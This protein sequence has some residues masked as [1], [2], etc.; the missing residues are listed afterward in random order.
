M[1]WQCFL[2]SRN[3]FASVDNHTL[4]FRIGMESLLEFAYTS[5]LTVNLTNIDDVICA[6]RELD[7]KNIEFS[8]LNYLKQ[9]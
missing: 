2:F 4:F 9:V 5:K 7:F 3:F 6:A 8:C 1:F